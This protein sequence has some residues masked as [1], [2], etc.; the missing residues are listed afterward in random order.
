MYARIRKAREDAGYTR[1]K[2]A[3][4]LDVSVSY[5]AEV[6]R[7]HTNVSVKTLIKICNVLGLS[8]D[9]VLFGENREADTLLLEKIHRL[10]KKYLP[11]LTDLIN[12]LLALYEKE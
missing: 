4:L 5:L 6:E 9:Y 10:D 2:F 12:D 11:L 8:A 3:E 7:G 1:E